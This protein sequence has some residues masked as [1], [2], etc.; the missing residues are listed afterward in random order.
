V[1][2]ETHLEVQ[3][4]EDSTVRVQ[5]EH[6]RVA[7]SD[8]AQATVHS[9][10]EPVEIRGISGEVRLETRH[11]QVLVS[12]VEG[13]LS[14]DSRHGD[15]E[16]S[17]LAR[18]AT[19]KVRR[20]SATLTRLGAAVVEMDYGDL[21][22]ETVRGDL[23]VT[24]EHALVTARDVSGAARVKTSYRAVELRDVA[25]DAS[26]ETSHGGVSLEN[27]GGRARAVAS[28]DD[29]ILESVEGPVEVTV[30]HGSVRGRQLANGGRVAASGDDVSLIGFAGAFSV[31]AERGDVHLEPG[32]PI[33]APLEV[34]ADGAVYLAVPPG[35][36]LELEATAP[37]ETIEADV[38]LLEILD[39]KEHAL[40]ARVGEGGV[41]VTLRATRGG[42][43]LS[44]ATRPS[45]ESHSGR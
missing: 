28:F 21:R 35:S 8:V 40:T 44:N 36:H 42:I 6:G 13:P 14:L 27:V 2:L 11:A 32:G 29:V 33:L 30:S 3:V 43:H 9:S 37:Q 19:L 34:V 7:V 24:A 1:G 5:S 12:N 10:Y 23:E 26:A 38:A 4:P 39:S 22:A 41:R 15:V 31:T 16:V 20:G 25:G 45:P 18:P 17:D